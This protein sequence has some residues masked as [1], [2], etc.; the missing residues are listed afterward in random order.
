MEKTCVIFLPAPKAIGKFTKNLK[1]DPGILLP[2]ELESG[3]GDFD[4]EKISLEMVLSG[5]L[6][7]ISAFG[8]NYPSLT[9]PFIEHCTKTA[10]KSGSI[11]S[12][13]DLTNIPLEWIDYYRRFVLTVKPEIYHEFTSASIIKARNEEFDMALEI[14]AVLEGLFPLSPGVLLNRA[15]ILE[16]KAIALEKKGHCAE[17]ENAEAL[18]AYEVALS[19]KPVLPDTLFNAGFFFMRRGTS[20]SSIHALSDL[21]EPSRR[22]NFAKA[23]VCFTRYIKGGEESEIPRD[24]KRQAKKLIKELS[25]LEDPDFDEAYD[26]IRRG[27]EEEGLVKIREFIE[28]HPLVWNGWFLLGWALRK[29]SRYGDALESFKKALELAKTY[30]CDIMNEMAIC[31]ME[32]GDLKGAKKELERALRKEP[33]NIKIISNLGVLAMKAGN[34]DQAVAFF[35]TVLSIDPEDPLA[36]HYLEER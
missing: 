3:K 17:K 27:N 35:R 12:E 1:A 28:R 24:K 10:I 13:S 16:D 21:D 11:F 14:N 25:I 2:L 22:D 6:R 32:L 26:C 34:K 18:G 20:G 15:L 23:R 19:L 8:R 4:A 7:I 33:E 36:K 5:M 9:S 29:L 30:N 31:L